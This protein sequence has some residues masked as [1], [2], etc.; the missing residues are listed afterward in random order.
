MDT[1][2]KKI[3]N[4]LF[5]YYDEEEYINYLIEIYENKS[6][7]EHMFICIDENNNIIGNCIAIKPKQVANKMLALI[8]KQKN[9]KSFRIKLSVIK[10]NKDGEKTFDYIVEQ[11][12]LDNPV[13]MDIKGDDITKQITYSYNCSIRR[14]KS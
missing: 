8:T 2:I 9:N 5:K 14:F 13:V 11:T 1:E 10:I 4:I 3:V 6:A 7:R 12:K